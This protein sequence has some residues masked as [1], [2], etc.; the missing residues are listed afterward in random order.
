M[1]AG[2]RYRWRAR[3]RKGEVKCTEAVQE[4]APK[5]GDLLGGRYVVGQKRERDGAHVAGAEAGERGFPR[6]GLSGAFLYHARNSALGQFS[7]FHSR[8]LFL[9]VNLSPPAHITQHR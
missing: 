1:Y 3:W 4:E 8:P 5:A 6:W 2:R 7:R 9:I